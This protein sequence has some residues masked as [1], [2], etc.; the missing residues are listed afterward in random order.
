VKG[1]AA[2]EDTPYAVVGSVPVGVQLQSDTCASRFTMS[3]MD[4]LCSI[5]HNAT[6][7]RKMWRHKITRAGQVSIPAEVRERWSASNVLI[8]DEGDRLVMQPA[9]DSPLEAIRGILKGK[10]RSDISATEAIRRWREE[11]NAAMERKWREYYGG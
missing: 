11:D 9:P 7:P 4:I 10:G 1:V 8:V 6:M 2:T 3:V 5:E